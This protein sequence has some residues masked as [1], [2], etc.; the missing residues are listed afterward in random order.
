M[1]E[2]PL[3]AMYRDT[4][5]LCLCTPFWRYNPVWD[6]RSVFLERPS[7]ALSPEPSLE[8]RPVVVLFKKHQKVD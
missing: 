1:G 8:G 6:D 4:G 3:Y 7:G 5:V 2:A